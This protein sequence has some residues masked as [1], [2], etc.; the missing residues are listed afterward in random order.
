M[1]LLKFKDKDIQNISEE[2]LVQRENKNSKNN[3]PFEENC[4]AGKGIWGFRNESVQQM[5]MMINI[6]ENILNLDIYNY[7]DLA[8]RNNKKRRFLFVSKVLGKHLP[9]RA[10]D[11]DNLGKDIVKVYEKKQDYLNSGVV[12]SF[13]ETGTALGHSVFNYINADYEFIHTTREKIQ[14]KKS[15]DFLEEHSHATNHNLYYEDLKYLKDKEEIILVDDEIT[16]GNTCI[17]LI[18]KANEL[19][20]KKRYTICSI[21][22]WMNDEAFDRFKKSQVYKT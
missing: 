1:S 17:N 9:C 8:I 11:M 10:C 18:K 20:P 21:L 2:E 14:N 13:A 6:K 15:L 22:N 7:L 12:I 3:L 19:F 16:T 5:R 4:K